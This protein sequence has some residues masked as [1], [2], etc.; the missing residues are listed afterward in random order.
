VPNLPPISTNFITDIRAA[1][2]EIPPDA[3]VVRGY[4]G[5]PTG[6]LEHAN[7]ILA[8]YNL[9]GIDPAAIAGIDNLNAA[10]GPPPDTAPW[11]IYLTGRLDSWVEIPDWNTC[12]VHVRQDPNTDRVQAFT[13][14]LRTTNPETCCPI[15][16]RV[17][18]ID[19]LGP[20]DQFVAGRM[21][22]DYMA[23]TE[24]RKVVWDEQEYG[25]TTGKRSTKY[26][27]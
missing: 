12:V 14:W 10:P 8:A 17:V 16:Y 27:F 19:E 4:L 11:R 26:C 25:P 5:P 9:P 23:R 1:G 2:L 22:E 15:R 3:I 13:V 6:V 21:V 7:A 18:T 20:D 24:S